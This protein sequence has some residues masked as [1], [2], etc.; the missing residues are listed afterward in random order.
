[1]TGK[2]GGI[3]EDPMFLAGEVE[4]SPLRR[5]RPEGKG[6]QGA[7]EAWPHGVGISWGT[8]GGI[9]EMGGYEPLEIKDQRA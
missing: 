6:T 7:A 3:E 5:A 2:V 1:M 4:G 9:Q 8:S